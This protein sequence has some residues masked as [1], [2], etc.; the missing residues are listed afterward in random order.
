[1]TDDFVIFSPIFPC[2]CEH[3]ITAHGTE[4]DVAYA[5]QWDDDHREEVEVEYPYPR[6]I[7]YECGPGDCEFVE[8]TNLE[9]LEFKSNGNN[10]S[11]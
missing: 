3:S 5:W 8:M 7:C 1:M 6:P 10:T 2:I 11:T 9:Y 4:T